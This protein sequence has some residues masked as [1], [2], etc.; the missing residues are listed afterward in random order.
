MRRVLSF[1][2][3]RIHVAG[4]VVLRVLEHCAAQ[5]SVR[6]SLG[7]WGLYRVSLWNGAVKL[8]DCVVC[9]RGL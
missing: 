2:C 6:V 1:M 7:N 3:L 9:P 8:C 4:C 5:D